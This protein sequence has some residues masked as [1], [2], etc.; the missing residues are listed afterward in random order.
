MLD[1]FPDVQA[2]PWGGLGG[3]LALRLLLRIFFLMR[4]L[5][6]YLFFPYLLEPFGFSPGLIVFYFCKVTKVRDLC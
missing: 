2:T 1:F 4:N 5:S 3:S 6:H